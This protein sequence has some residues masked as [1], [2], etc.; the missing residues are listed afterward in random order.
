MLNCFRIS[1]QS[2]PHFGSVQLRLMPDDLNH[3]IHRFCM[4]DHFCAIATE[5]AEIV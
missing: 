2:L 3:L 5:V 1:G 4:W